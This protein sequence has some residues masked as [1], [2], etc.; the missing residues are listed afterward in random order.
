MGHQ[1]VICSALENAD[2]TVLVTLKNFHKGSGLILSRENSIKKLKS[3]GIKDAAELDFLKISKMLPEDYIK[4]LKSE[5]SPTLIVSGYNHTFGYNKGGNSKLLEV[6]QKKFGYRYI[7]VPPLTFEGEIVSSNL[8][9]KYLKEGNTEK[10]ARMLGS[11]FT[12]EGIVI[13]GQKLG[14][15]LGFPTANITY[16]DN[17]VKIPFG[18]YKVKVSDKPGVM[19]WGARPTVKGTSEPV[20]EVHILDFDG[21]LYG[22]MI[23]IEVIKKIRDEEKFN[24]LEELKYRIGEDIKA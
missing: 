9:K 15:K 22:K 13:S 21:N 17:I 5:F 4:Y 16:P 8:I 2:N 19:N 24:S 23:K 11:N 20:L 14:R 1:A 3:L 12:L 18:V 10:A 6:R 7:C